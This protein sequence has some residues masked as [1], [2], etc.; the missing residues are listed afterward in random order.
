MLPTQPPA[1]HPL[2]KELLK[3]ELLPYQLDGIAFAVGVG[4]AILADDMG[5]GKTIQ[6]IGVAE[7]LARLA[8][9][10]R[11]LIVCPASLKAQWRA[12]IARFS[13]RSCQVVL[14]S[15]EERAHRRRAVLDA[16]DRRRRHSTSDQPE[17]AL[18]R[19][20][21]SGWP[22]ARRPRA[23]APYGRHD[24]ERRDRR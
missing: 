9:I 1:R 19:R 18:R 3:T 14:G 23:V 22:S 8:D 13:N 21:D 11:V 12:E 5:L 6:A 20:C 2:R 24:L 15:A 10:R 7:L 17:A 4:R 16:V